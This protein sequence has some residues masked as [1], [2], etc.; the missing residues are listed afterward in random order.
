V[1]GMI[2][3]VDTSALQQQ[4]R[5]SFDRFE[6][7]AMKPVSLPVVPVKLLTSTAKMPTRGSAGAIAVDL[8]S[9]VQGSRGPIVIY[10]G[11]RRIISTGV[12]FAIPH[13]YY[14]RVAPRSGL[15]AKHGI[16]VL[17]GVID[18]DYRG[19]IFVILQNNASHCEFE[20][21]GHMRIAQMIFERADQLD[22]VQV[23]DLDDTTRGASGCGSTGVN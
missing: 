9:D 10:P 3:K 4:I 14:G 16:D 6:S 21:T 18:E 22:L 15:A 17:A 8:Y 7:M 5:E 1:V 20:V 2:L 12:A 11:T 13:G 19:E 23:D